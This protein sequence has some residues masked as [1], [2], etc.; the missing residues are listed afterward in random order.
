[1]RNARAR[2]VAVS[3]IDAETGELMFSEE[4]VL[5]IGEQSAAVIDRIYD[6]ASK[7]SG[8]SDNDLEEITKN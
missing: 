4:D 7:I 1:M 8:I 3:A 2:L 5:A 6:V